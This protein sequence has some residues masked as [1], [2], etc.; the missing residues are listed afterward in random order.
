MSTPQSRTHRRGDTAGV[1]VAGEVGPLTFPQALIQ[2]AT[3]QS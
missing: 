1:I 2:S 3:V